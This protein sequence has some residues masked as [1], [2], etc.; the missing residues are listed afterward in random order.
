MSRTNQSSCREDWAFTLIEL[1]VVIA[2]IAILAA[3]LLPALARAKAKAYRTACVNNQRQIGMAFRMYSDDANDNYPLHD[4]WAAVGGQRPTNAYTSGFAADYGGREWETN[5]PLNRYVGNVQTFHCP[6]DK[7]D[8]IN[9]G[10]NS[11][12]DAWG[13]SY[14]VAWGD[15]FR[16]KHVTASA[17]KFYPVG[18]PIKASEIA[19]RPVTKLI[20]GDWP[21]HGNRTITDPRSVW[22]N[23]RGRRAEAILFGDIHI[24]FYKFPPDAEM[25]DGTLPDPNYK[26]W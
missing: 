22:H 11:C 4:G 6:A 16:V 18:T 3:M 8:A 1:L 12:W 7:G 13:N 25:N 2:I 9:P 10:V 5:R 26:F 14:L 20:Q 19:R 23:V 15:G 21:W 17:G 24:E